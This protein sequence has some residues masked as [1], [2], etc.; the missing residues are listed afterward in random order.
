MHIFL[1]PQ[2]RHIIDNLLTDGVED[3]S[4]GR[5]LLLGNIIFLLLILISVGG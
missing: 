1:V 3:I 5:A 4:A 2:T